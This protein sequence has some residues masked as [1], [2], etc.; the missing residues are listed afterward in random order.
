MRWIKLDIT[1]IYFKKKL[2]VAL[3]LHRSFVAIE[4]IVWFF[5]IFGLVRF[6]S[7]Q[8]VPSPLFPFPGA[9]S[10]LVDVTIPSRRVTLSS[11]GVKTSSL[12]PL[13]FPATLCFVVSHLEP[14][15][16]HWIRITA[17]DHHPRTVWLLSSTTIK[18]SSQPWPLSPSLNRVF[19]LI[20]H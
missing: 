5:F 9:A 6:T 10:P 1:C 13:H 18:M 7:A 11:H 19:I 4:S 3:N 15:P 17:I 8:L 12:R 16:N 14:K 2:I 20:P